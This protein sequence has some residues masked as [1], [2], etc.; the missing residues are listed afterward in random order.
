MHEHELFLKEKEEIDMLLQND[1]KIVSVK[2]NLSGAFVSFQLAD[3]TDEERITTLHL[4]TPD[5]R[6]YLTNQ[7]STKKM[8]ESRT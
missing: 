6:I 2:E 5:A 4:L 8:E 7:L 1:C 3:Q